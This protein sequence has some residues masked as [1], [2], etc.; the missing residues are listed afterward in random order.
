MFI[1]VRH[2]RRFALGLK[3][4]TK[5]LW[6]EAVLSSLRA[7]NCWLILSK[8]IFLSTTSECYWWWEGFSVSL[9]VLRQEFGNF[10][11]ELAL[12]SCF[13]IWLHFFG[14]VINQWGFVRKTLRSELIE[15]ATK[16]W[17]RSVTLRKGLKGAVCICQFQFSLTAGKTMLSF[18]TRTALDCW[19]SV[20]FVTSSGG[21]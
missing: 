17:L 2:L 19:D 14:S 21:V 13:N 16:L 15:F 3:Q 18:R 4:Y 11:D 5:A 20:S 9:R 6:C 12:R 10:N 8:F 1:R 7:R